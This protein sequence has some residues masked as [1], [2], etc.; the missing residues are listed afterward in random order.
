[1]TGAAYAEF[2]EAVKGKLVPGMLADIVIL[3]QNIFTTT[4]LQINEA[5][6]ALTIVDGRMVYER[7]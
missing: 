3:S 7:K 4:D 6:V 1:M 2:T 5:V